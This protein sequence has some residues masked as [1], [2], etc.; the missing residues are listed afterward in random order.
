M[1]CTY[2]LQARIGV[3][4]CH[5]A[6]VMTRKAMYEALCGTE[7]QR[8]RVSRPRHDKTC[9]WSLRVADCDGK[10]ACHPCTCL[11]DGKSACHPCTCLCDGKSACHPCTCLCDGKSACHPCTCLCGL[12]V[13]YGYFVY[14]CAIYEHKEKRVFFSSP[15]VTV[16]TESNK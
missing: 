16:L 3:V 14:C 15:C 2:I 1:T 6:E 7:G 4:K 11:C 9:E 10:S 5:L 8:E 13:F 12:T